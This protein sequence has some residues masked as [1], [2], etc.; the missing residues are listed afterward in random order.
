MT[1]I[2]NIVSEYGQHCLYTVSSET[3]TP[4][5]SETMSQFSFVVLL[6]FDEYP[7]S[8]STGASKKRT[9]F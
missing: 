3:T 8:A 9:I 2:A 7:I 5:G 4:S 1:S 6:P